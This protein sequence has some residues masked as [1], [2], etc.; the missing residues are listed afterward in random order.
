MTGERIR[1]LRREMGLKQSELGQKLG[2]SASAVGMYEND[3]RVPPR[4]TLLKMCEFFGVSTDYLLGNDDSRQQE[5]TTDLEDE[6]SALREKLIRQ[7]GLM[8]HGKPLSPESL[9]K[10]LRAVR[11]GAELAFSEEEGKL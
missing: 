4:E 11:L 9:E 5:Q 1:Q 2:I 7:D 10:I 6:L 3:R 8:F